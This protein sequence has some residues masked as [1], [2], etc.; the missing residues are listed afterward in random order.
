[1]EKQKVYRLFDNCFFKYKN[2]PIV[3]YGLGINTK[4]LLEEAKAYKIVGIAANDRIG[5]TVYGKEVMPIEAVTGKAGIIVII[6]QV[7]SV[8]TIYERIK[9]IEDTGI[10]IFDLYGRMLKEY[11]D[12]KNPNADN[13]PSFESASAMNHYERLLCSSV[14]NVVQHALTKCDYNVLNLFS[15]KAFDDALSFVKSNGKVKINNMYELGYF[16]FAP[17]TVKFLSWLVKE[18]EDI[19]NSIILFSSR[20]GYLLH[21][22]YQLLKSRTPGLK[23]PDAEYFYISRRAITVACIQNESDIIDDV[24]LVFNLSMGNIKNILEQR[25]GIVFDKHDPILNRSLTEI[26]GKKEIDKITEIVLEYKAEI[27]ENADVERK[28]YLKY[29]QNLNLKPYKNIF[30]F[31][32]YPR[33]TNIM[34][35]SK[36][37]NRKIK[38]LCFAVKDYPNEYVNSENDYRS[39]FD[40]TRIMSGEWFRRV[41]QLFEIVYSSPEGQIKCFDSSGSPLFIENSQ[42]NYEYINEAQKGIRAFINDLEAFDDKWYRDVYSLDMVDFMIGMLLRK[43]S[44]VSSEIC[45]GFLYHDSFSLDKAINIWD[46]II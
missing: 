40:S 3:L 12:N 33:G 17:I 16:C 44:I 31:D 26:L 22:L 20:D 34:N 9:H 5:E 19:E 42:Y 15:R 41:Y 11:Y 32:L 18:L 46:S 24:A 45:N 13:C 14:A 37:I 39:M 29:L 10:M 35:L 25:L 28:N 36:L 27:L 4:Y 1:M 38:L 7:K 21:K 2:I 8:K 43:Y 30:L 6:A 23:L